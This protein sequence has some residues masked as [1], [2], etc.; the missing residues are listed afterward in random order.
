MG[1]FEVLHCLPVYWLFSLCMA[2]CYENW[3]VSKQV[4]EW[5]FATVKRFY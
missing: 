5:T 1:Y 2:P 4:G 3:R